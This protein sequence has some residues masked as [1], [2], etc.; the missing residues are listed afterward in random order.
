MA[1]GEGAGTEE[2]PSPAPLI[3]TVPVTLQLDPEALRLIADLSE[4]LH[5]D[6]ASVLGEALT[7]YSAVKQAHDDGGQVIVPSGVMQ[8][9]FKQEISLR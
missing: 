8:T 1:T 9:K 6:P 4:K 7:F 2:K 3:G 5:A